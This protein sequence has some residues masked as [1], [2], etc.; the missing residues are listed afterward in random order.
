MSVG[1]DGAKFGFVFAEHHAVDVHFLKQR[2]NILARFADE[3]VRK[4][5]AVAKNNSQSGFHIFTPFND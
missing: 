5:I 4:K 1:L 2:Q 3:M